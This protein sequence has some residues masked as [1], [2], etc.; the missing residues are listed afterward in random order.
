M[1]I[2]KIVIFTPL[3][4]TFCF[5]L[6]IVCVGMCVCVRVYVCVCPCV[7]VCVWYKLKEAQRL[8]RESEAKVGVPR[9]CS[10]LRHKHTLNASKFDV[11]PL[12]LFYHSKQ[13]SEQSNRR[14]R[15]LKIFPN[16]DSAKLNNVS[17]G[18]KQSVF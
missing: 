1:I 17:F 10:L 15:N 8:L 11:K 13:T 14:E 7:C 18:K 12:T 16:R 3:C 5:C 9:A 6:P 4:V 2:K